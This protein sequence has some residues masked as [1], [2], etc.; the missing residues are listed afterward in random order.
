MLA[1]HS[2]LALV[3]CSLCAPAGA[4][5][6]PSL[7]GAGA[8]AP[9]RAPA[10][11]PAPAEPEPAASGVELGLL[12]GIESSNGDSSD[13]ALRG[14]VIFERAP[15]AD[16]VGFS[17]V[18]SLAFT[19]WSDE[20]TSYYQR[21]EARLNLF[22]IVPAVRLTLG[23]NPGLRPYVDAGIGFY[24]YSASYSVT[25]TTYG[26]VLETSQSD[27]GL[28]LR[29]A[30][31]VLFRVGESFSLGAEL[32]FNEHSGSEIDSSTSG[33]VVATLKL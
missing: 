27:S 19:N 18:G 2:T 15:I 17:F 13:L 29:L 22:R 23:S 5:A 4:L 14:D 33:S 25:D 28:A 21:A 12:A 24:T 26:T 1:R 9:A 10:P 3:V 31:G 11:A 16:G 7:I 8:R 6:A 32:T 20:A 30:G